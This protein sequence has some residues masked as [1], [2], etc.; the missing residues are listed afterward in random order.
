MF[1]LVLF[2]L[3]GLVF[4]GLFFVV[5]G[6]SRHKMP[7]YCIFKGFLL[8]SLPNPLLPNPSLFCSSSLSFSFQNPSF[9][10]FCNPFSKE[11]CCPFLPFSNIHVS[12]S[13][14]VF[15]FVVPKQLPKY[16]LLKPKLLAFLSCVFFCFSLFCCCYNTSFQFNLRIATKSSKHYKNRG[17]REIW[18][19]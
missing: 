5:Y 7:F 14:L 18:K 17:L 10:F 3:C 4:V 15:C 13:F 1:G 12:Y 16:P 11:P 19:S 9:L 8:L 6:F 2:C